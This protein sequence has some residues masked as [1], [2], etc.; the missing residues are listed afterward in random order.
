MRGVLVLG[1]AAAF[2]LFGLKGADDA[3]L[4]IIK[5]P[6]TKGEKGPRGKI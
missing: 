1:G 2:T 4:P 6:Q 5:G 3:N